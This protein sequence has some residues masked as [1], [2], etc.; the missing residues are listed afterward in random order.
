M[1]EITALS[2]VVTRILDVAMVI[3][4]LAMAALVVMHCVWEGRND[5]DEGGEP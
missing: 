1:F 4:G 2:P 5:D 3:T